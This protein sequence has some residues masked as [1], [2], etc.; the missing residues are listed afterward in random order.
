MRNELTG[1]A[2]AA[3]L[4]VL[5]GCKAE[6]PLALGTLEWDRVTLPSP[7]A[8][9]IV[10]I[11]V[12]EGEQVAEGAPLLQL[13]LTR[14]QSQLAAVQAQAAQSRE[15]LA[16]LRA[17][18]RSEDVAQ[19]RASLAAAQAQARDADAY[20]ARLQPLG[21]Q[22]LVAASEVDRARAA[23]QSAQAQVRLA[24]AA[25]LELERGTR[26]EQVAQGAAAVATAEAQA[27]VQAVTLDKLNVVAPRA[28]RIDSLPY[29]LGDQAPVGAPLAVMLVGDAPYARVYLPQALRNE[30]KVGDSVQVRLDGQEKTYAGRL[31]MVRSEPSFT[32][33]FALTGQDAARLSYL[34]EISLGKEAADLPVGAPL[35]VV[36]HGNE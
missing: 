2:F 26:S 15:A 33:Y 18:P 30:M 29:K 10:R 19:A 35:Q 24:Q 23:S 13:E 27:A 7:V 31:R 20:Y 1:A 14:T 11:D 16:E 5:A 32:P 17:G 34:A 8:E 9:K 25:L 21:R 28:G 12:R 6:A 3:A 22:Q 36:S 4:L